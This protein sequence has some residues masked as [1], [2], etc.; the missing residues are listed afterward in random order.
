M[1]SQEISAI[2]QVARR[3]PLANMAEA[4]ALAQLLHKLATHF[5]PKVGDVP[6]ADATAAESPK[7]VT[8]E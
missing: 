3:A 4:E 5:A 7:P 6:S 2:I 8:G 1:N